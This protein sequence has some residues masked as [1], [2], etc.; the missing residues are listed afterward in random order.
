MTQG[1]VF[2]V[3]D[4]GA[5]T[6]TF[7]EDDAAGQALV[8]S[9][10][11]ISALYSSASAIFKVAGIDDACR[12]LNRLELEKTKLDLEYKPLKF[13][14]NEV[15]RT[16]TT[17]VEVAQRAEYDAE[18]TKRPYGV[19]RQFK[20]A[21][22]VLELCY[23]QEQMPAHLAK[24]L[25]Q[26]SPENRKAKL[27]F[28]RAMGRNWQRR[29]NKLH[30]VQ[31]FV[32]LG[33]AD[34]EKDPEGDIKK[35]PRLYTD[36]LADLLTET[37]R[38][39]GLAKGLPL[40]RYLTAARAVVAEFCTN[41]ANIYAPEWTPELWM[42]QFS[43]KFEAKKKEKVSKAASA[44]GFKDWENL[45]AALTQRAKEAFKLACEVGLDVDDARQELFQIVSDAFADEPTT[46][47]GGGGG[48][49]A[50]SSVITNSDTA[51]STGGQSAVFSTFSA[52]DFANSL[53]KNEDSAGL[54]TTS[55][56][57]LNLP[58]EAS[59]RA[60]VEAC[61]SVGA[62]MWK[63]AFTAIYPLIGQAA[64]LPYDERSEP[65]KNGVNMSGAELISRIPDYI[66]RNQE[67]QH[68]IAVR[69]WGALFQVDDASE[70]FYE[71]LKPFCF[72]AIRTSPNS[73][74]AWI[75]LA[76]DFLGADGK[77]NDALVEVRKRFFERCEELGESANGGA[78]NSIR[79]PGTLNIK[80]KHAPDFPRIQLVHVAMGHRVTPEE[81]DAAG[82]LAPVQ[83]PPLRLVNPLPRALNVTAQRL[84]H[85]YFVQ[86]QPNL[87]RADASFVVH[88]LA[89][90][91]SR[92][93]VEAE[94]R[95]VRDK[96]ARRD[97]Y[98]RRTLDAAE[99][100]LATH[101]ATGRQ[102]VAI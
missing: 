78:Y 57:H 102:R 65:R 62:T 66:R 42:T 33:L 63:A 17:I 19:A 89:L 85:S 47:T 55:A 34:K 9:R 60:M 39:A 88:R 70:E 37:A 84:D 41:E 16:Y 81:L 93:E 91:D 74:Q 87:S 27:K 72:A 58:P 50:V 15:L 6:A 80:E 14:A 90:G 28:I 64:D 36:R 56:S 100:Y 68:N 59:A 92:W 49:E 48:R 43:E 20:A 61:E 21:A 5:S 86:R 10:K 22:Y 97:D 53:S 3:D 7:S 101:P 46:P 51:F 24:K 82:L 95:A 18:Q 75:A 26:L 4:V 35:S 79:M 96:A 31:C 30:L 52:S 69:V 32:H 40:A 25:D 38:R 99:H 76:G 2:S 71:R 83:L 11:K 94:L 12:Q 67:R 45:K 29:Y 77:R 73:W 44:P 1:K 98:V 8:K 13:D 23:R 54:D